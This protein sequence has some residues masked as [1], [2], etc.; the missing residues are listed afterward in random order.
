[1]PASEFRKKAISFVIFTSIVALV[2]LAIP[3]IFEPTINDYLYQYGLSLTP[4]G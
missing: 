3:F 4:A 2:L 1:M